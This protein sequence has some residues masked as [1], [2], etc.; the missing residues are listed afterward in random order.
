M[1]RA[2]LLASVGVVG[3]VITSGAE[4]IPITFGT[5]LAPEIA[6]S[7]GTGSAIVVYDD[8]AHS[9]SVSVQ[10]SNLTGTTTVA[11]IHC[12]VAP[13]GTVGVATTPGTFPGFP[14]GVTSGSYEG[15]WS[16]AQTSSY[17]DEFLTASGGT[18]ASAEAALISGI[19]AGRAYVNVHTA[20]AP[21]GEIRGFLAQVPEP[22]VLGL[23]ITGLLGL[24]GMRRRSSR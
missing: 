20:F 10:F 7:S 1:L 23:L 2:V 12:C 9:L 13:P 8:A 6:G 3:L 24:V 17:T 16:L 14:A 21:G 19:E 15:T 5:K 18:A 11:H 22:G 4:A